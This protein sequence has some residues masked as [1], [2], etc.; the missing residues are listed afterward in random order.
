MLLWKCTWPR[1][2]LK[3]SMRRL[4]WTEVVYQEAPAIATWN[5][6][7]RESK[8]MLVLWEARL[9]ESEGSYVLVARDA[10][11]SP[12]LGTAGGT[13]TCGVM[14]AEVPFAKGLDR[15]ACRLANA[16]VYAIEGTELC[17]RCVRK[18]RGCSRR[19]QAGCCRNRGYQKY[20]VEKGLWNYAVA[21]KNLASF[22]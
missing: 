15:S 4:G 10:V 20:C 16:S 21:D 3:E 18:A 8:V 22:G 2:S 7:A 14:R 19:G 11:A 17:R 12:L 13:F 6:K 1:S 5:V 9:L